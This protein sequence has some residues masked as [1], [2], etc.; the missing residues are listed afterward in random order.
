[1]GKDPWQ[2]KIEMPWRNIIVHL[3]S[4]FYLPSLWFNVFQKKKRKEKAYNDFPLKILTDS[5]KKY[6]EKNVIIVVW[7]NSKF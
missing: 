2:K 6:S 5:E 1:M 4:V 3:L 7:K